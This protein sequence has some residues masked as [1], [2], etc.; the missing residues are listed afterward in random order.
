VRLHALYFKALPLA[1]RPFGII[2]ALL[3]RASPSLGLECADVAY[4]LAVL[5][6]D[7]RSRV[8]DMP[9]CDS[10]GSYPYGT[11]DM[12]PKITIES[13]IMDPQ[14]PAATTTLDLSRDYLHMSFICSSQ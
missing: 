14:I 12:A 5:V 7:G 3:H 10:F 8:E 13:E 11:Y 2:V 1:M 4:L 6:G 9:S